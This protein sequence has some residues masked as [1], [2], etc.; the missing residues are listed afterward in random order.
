MTRL[1]AP[2]RRSI[3]RALAVTALTVAAL[4]VGPA[5]GSA[6]AAPPVFTVENVS[7]SEGDPVVF[8]VLCTDTDGPGVDDD[9]INSI[10]LGAATSQPSTPANGTATEDV[11]YDAGGPGGSSF[12]ST[13]T[14]EATPDTETIS[15]PTFEDGAVENDET[16]TLTLGVGDTAIGT[17]IDDDDSSPSPSGNADLA[18][19]K[20]ESAD[21]ARVGDYG[22]R[23][24]A[25]R[26]GTGMVVGIS[27]KSANSEI[28]PL[29]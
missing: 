22:R 27:W 26:E 6:M 9:C 3:T 5:V 20:V 16:F 4:G 10:V 13:G 8:T 25:G 21:P 19:G 23:L 1:P 14:F 24:R 11:D 18:V 12:Y 28:G 29:P 7:A 15:V 17:I 2:L